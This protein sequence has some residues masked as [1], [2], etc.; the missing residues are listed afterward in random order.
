MPQ[1]NK[2][3]LI[4]VLL[5]PSVFSLA[6]DSSSNKVNDL[7][8]LL[9]SWDV[10][11]GSEDY[12]PTDEAEALYF[13]HFWSIGYKLNFL[14]NMGIQPTKP[15]IEHTIEYFEFQRIKLEEAIVQKGFSASTASLAIQEKYYKIIE[16]SINT[17][18]REFDRRQN[19]AQFQFQDFHDCLDD[20]I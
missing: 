6:E 4:I 14:M 2:F 19:K 1:I 3:L 10:K 16:K 7:F 9:S 8:R 13:T 12:N 15:T 5:F 17:L 11:Q 18:Q 20:Q